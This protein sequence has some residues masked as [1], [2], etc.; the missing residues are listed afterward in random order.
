[1]PIHKPRKTLCRQIHK[2]I[3]RGLEREL[4]VEFEHTQKK[5]I[6]WRISYLDRQINDQENLLRYHNDPKRWWFMAHTEETIQINT[7][8]QY[9]PY[10]ISVLR[11]YLEIEKC[12]LENHLFERLLT[13][14]KAVIPCSSYHQPRGPYVQRAVKRKQ[15]ADAKRRAHN[16]KRAPVETIDDIEEIVRK[17]RC[18][19]QRGFKQDWRPTRDRY[20]R[21]DD[22]NWK[23]QG[24][25]NDRD[26]YP[27]FE[28]SPDFLQLG[29]IKKPPRRRVRK[30]WMKNL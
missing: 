21:T 11:K 28:Y 22:R 23:K 2:K 5:G 10:C 9:V 19:H 12:E 25:Y 7:D 1:M 30:Q 18:R 15:R 17:D 26:H 6:L 3:R 27:E 24:R 4:D 8:P 13:D 14:E 20:W 16:P 29:V